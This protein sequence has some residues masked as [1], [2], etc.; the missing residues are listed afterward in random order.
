[1]FIAKIDGLNS[2]GSATVAL[3]PRRDGGV[4]LTLP[5]TG[6]GA[7]FDLHATD[8]RDEPNFVC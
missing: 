3:N 4:N 1:M 8:I 2:Q 6:H 7:L 5:P